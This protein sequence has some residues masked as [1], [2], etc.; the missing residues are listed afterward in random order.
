MDWA[1]REAVWVITGRV[2][3]N[4]EQDAWRYKSISLGLWQ[5]VVNRRKICWPRR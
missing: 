1:G 5:H 3:W 4:G 2:F